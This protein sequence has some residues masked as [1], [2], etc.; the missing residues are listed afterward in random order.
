[1]KRH[2]SQYG[3]GTNGH[4][5]SYAHEFSGMT[6][7]VEADGWGVRHAASGARMPL[8]RASPRLAHV[9]AAHDVVSPAHRS[10]RARELVFFYLGLAA[11]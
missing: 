10:A 4:D 8:R 9:S 7:E 2:E 5:R 3:D 11:R 1:M 6:D